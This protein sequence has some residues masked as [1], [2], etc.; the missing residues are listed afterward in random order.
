MELFFRTQAQASAPKTKIPVLGVQKEEKVFLQSF[1]PKTGEKM[2]ELES[3]KHR[4]TSVWEPGAMLQVAKPSN[5]DA[6]CLL[7]LLMAD[8]PQLCP[9]LKATTPPSGRTQT[10]AP[11]KRVTIWLPYSPVIKYGMQRDSI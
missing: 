1:F 9:W 11:N 3:M 5:A 8:K 7:F 10:Q 4:Q 2:S 6:A